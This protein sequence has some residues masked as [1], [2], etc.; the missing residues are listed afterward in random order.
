MK[1]DPKQQRK[2]EGEKRRGW[3][4]Y[5]L[6]A[7]KPKPLDFASILNL[8]DARNFPMSCRRFAEELDFLRSVGLIRVF[9]I[10]ADSALDEV[11]QSK[12]I[13]KYCESEGELNDD[14]CAKLTTK[15]TNFQEEYFNLDGLKRVN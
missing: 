9:P 10:G 15:G 4:V 11:A 12:L 14:Y 6:Y 1:F 5:L 2:I 3:I 8:M 13:Q 7:A